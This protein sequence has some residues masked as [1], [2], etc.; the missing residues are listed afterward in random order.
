MSIFH[1]YTL[2]QYLISSTTHRVVTHGF[3]PGS[4]S[5]VRVYSRPLF[6]TSLDS[7]SLLLG[8][9]QP[10]GIG[11]ALSERTPGIKKIKK[12]VTESLFLFCEAHFSGKKILKSIWAGVISAGDIG[13]EWRHFPMTPAQILH[14]M[15]PPCQIDKL[16]KVKG[17]CYQRSWL[18]TLC[19]HL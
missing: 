10:C 12:Y 3:K 16:L 5:G 6:V 11:A 19:L 15:F 1:F 9:R 4:L 7:L 13:L 18:Q 8:E 14:K 2:T 17:G